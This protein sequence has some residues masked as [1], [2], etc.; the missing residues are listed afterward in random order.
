MKYK[1]AFVKEIKKEYLWYKDELES[2]FKKHGMDQ[3]FVSKIKPVSMYR[4]YPEEIFNALE[5]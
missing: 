3:F 1:L 5:K 4:W 2:L